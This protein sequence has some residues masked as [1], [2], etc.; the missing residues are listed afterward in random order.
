ME[1]LAAR[2]AAEEARFFRAED[3]NALRRR[4]ER[5]VRGQAAASGSTSTT[6][7]AAAARLNDFE[8]E[9]LAARREGLAS[10]SVSV[11]RTANPL[12]VDIDV[13]G[14]AR[15]V[16]HHSTFVDYLNV[17]RVSSRPSGPP[18]AET[19]FRR[20]DTHLFLSFSSLAARCRQVS[21][22]RSKWEVHQDASV[23]SVK[24]GKKLATT[25]PETLDAAARP[26]T[27]IEKAVLARQNVVEAHSVD[28]STYRGVR[29]YPKL[30]AGRAF[31]WGS[32]LAVWGTT[33]LVVSA[34]KALKIDSVEDLDTFVNKSVER[35]VER[36]R[37][38][39]EK[40]FR[41]ED[42][43]EYKKLQN[44]KF[45]GNLKSKWS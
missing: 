15:R 5:L 11:V 38:T 32:L 23:F 40:N 30:N 25:V 19:C 41:P 33:F 27:E 31:L 44:S 42:A 20:A 17:P 4:M 36:V 10:A 26:L 24:D 22:G 1:S 13:E 45:I 9:C 6:T 43:D 12:K 21:M 18:S 34:R 14:H 28:G 35:P 39:L 29:L 8:R 16:P 37:G 3:D 7:T 2:T